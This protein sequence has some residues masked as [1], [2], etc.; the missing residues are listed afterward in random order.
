M[1]AGESSL[2]ALFIQ[3]RFENLT[4]APLKVD[5]RDFTS[6][7]GNFAVRPDSLTIPASGTAEPDAMTSRL[8]LSGNSLAMTLV[9]SH[10]GHREERTITLNQRPVPERPER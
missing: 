2:P 1:M 4:Q 9:L 3:L 8:G 6:D 7:L 10:D 5:I